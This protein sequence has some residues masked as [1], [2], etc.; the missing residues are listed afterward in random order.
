MRTATPPQIERRRGRGDRPWHLV[1]YV[2][3]AFDLVTIGFSLYLNHRLNVSYEASVQANRQ[4]ATHLS[5]NRELLDLAQLVNAPGNDVFDSHDVSLELE[6]MNAALAKFDLAFAAER[7]DF[8]AVS[9]TV[10][11]ADRAQ[12]EHILDTM[13]RIP[14]SMKEMVDLE[15]EIFTLFR[16]NQAER[17]G[18]RMANMD[19]RYAKVNLELT[20]FATGVGRLQTNEFEAQGAVAARLRTLE[21]GVAAMLIPI[22]IAVALYGHYL[23]KAFQATTKRRLE[24][25]NGVRHAVLAATPECVLE[26]E[27]NGIIRSANPAAYSLLGYEAD[28]LDGMHVREVLPS[29][30]HASDSGDDPVWRRVGQTTPFQARRKDGSR[31]PCELRVS[32]TVENEGYVLVVRDVSDY[33]ARVE[34]QEAA[35]HAA[36][37]ANRAKSELLANMSHEIRTPMNSILGYA[38]LLLDAHSSASDRLNHVLTMRRNGQHLLTILNDILDLSRMEMGKFDVMPAEVE[39]AEVVA[40]VLSLMR[41]LA[42]DKGLAL[43]VHCTT[44][45]PETI[46]TDPT[47]L[48]QIFINLV[49]NAIKFTPSGKVELFVSSKPPSAPEPRLKVEISDTGIGLT[50]T[51]IGKLFHPFAQADGSTQRR[52]GGTGLG[53]VISRRLARALGGDV[54][55][56]SLPRRGSTFT[57]E[58]ATG[59][60]SRVPLVDE[61]C[62]TVA[63][64]DGSANL[65][66]ISARVLLAEDGFD[67]QALFK[68]ILTAAGANLVVVKNGAEAVAA[69]LESREKD[70]PFDIILMDMQMPELD[71]YGATAQLRKETWNGPIV[72]LTAHA[73]RGDRER[74]VAAGCDDVITKPVTR[75]RLLAGIARHLK[76]RPEV[77][78]VGEPVQYPLA[79]DL[80]H[81]VAPF[82]SGLSERL[83]LVEKLARAEEREEL[84][85]AAHDMKGTAG[86]F[87]F[88]AIS[89]A[90]AEVEIGIAENIGKEH[91][92]L[93]VERLASLCKRV[94]RSTN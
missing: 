69:A 79:P 14:A 62:T 68:A 76:K 67:N 7:A 81:L 4:W 34:A 86:S 16:A 84:R 80:E 55:V 10:R 56:K 94:I 77:D 88:P 6:R 91:L 44:A 65:P 78:T 35:R 29:D 19:R 75:E 22:V 85:K 30:D 58:I 8:V 20:A 9:D 36:E 66:Q 24:I 47:R 23:S 31:V 25:T 53:L 38:D 45:V 46:I 72:A 71:G 41:P 90:A 49:G 39:I 37:E 63:R 2:L 57:V 42:T 83:K 40:D 26:L 61:L 54:S 12:V 92:L 60:I 28:T 32:G 43:E 51:E 5:R 18:E 13:S 50:D 74:C 15:K 64:D 1:Y 3:A 59:D 82:V 27:D 48:R 93:R 89:A 52:Y 11:P 70:E 17:A 33:Q 87:G 73:M 21:F